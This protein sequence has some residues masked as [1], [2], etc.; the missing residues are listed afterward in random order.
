MGEGGSVLRCNWVRRGVVDTAIHL[1]QTRVE[2]LPPDG[3]LPGSHQPREGSKVRYTW[4]DDDDEFYS[5][6]NMPHL[7]V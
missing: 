7:A 2:G 1:A 5:E 6:R 3:R 4:L